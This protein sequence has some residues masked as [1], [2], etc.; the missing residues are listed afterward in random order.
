MRLR[1]KLRKK[2]IQLVVDYQH[3]FSA[4]KHDL[5]LTDLIEPTIAIRPGVAPIK[6]APYRAGYHANKEIENQVKQL[7]DKG[8]VIEAPGSSWSSLV[9]LV[10]K[11]DITARFCVD[12]RKLNTVI[13]S[14]AYPLPRIEE[15]L[16]CSGR[17]KAVL[18]IRYG[19]WILANTAK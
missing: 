13:E 14:P 9:V 19:F 18:H 2:L 8:L 12:Y 5:G 1:L 4:G 7:K 16:D 3:I 11:K 15:S 17:F 6:Q 10:L